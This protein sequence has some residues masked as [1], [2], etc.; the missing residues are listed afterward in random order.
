MHRDRAGFAHI[1]DIG[2]SW[3][4]AGVNITEDK[5]RVALVGQW[6]PMCE[7]HL[8]MHLCLPVGRVS[9]VD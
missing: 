4:T 7:W 5:T 9:T 6:I 1:A 8:A 2:Q 3:H